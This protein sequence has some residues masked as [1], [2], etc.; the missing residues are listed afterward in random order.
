[1]EGS[2]LS[3]DVTIFAAVPKCTFSLKESLR[4]DPTWITDEYYVQTYSSVN[5][6]FL[7]TA[8]V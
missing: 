3:T 7:H 8:I 4:L 1:M 6:E 5:I 2:I